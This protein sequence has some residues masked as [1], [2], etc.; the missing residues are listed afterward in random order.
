MPGLQLPGGPFVQVTH[1][2]E[3]CNLHIHA[4][5]PHGQTVMIF[6]CSPEQMLEQA[7]MVGGELAGAMRHEANL[8]LDFRAQLR[9]VTF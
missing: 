9:E 2:Q 4:D 3:M 1:T 7:D 8:A 5:G 6:D